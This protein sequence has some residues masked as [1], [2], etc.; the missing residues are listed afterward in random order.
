MRPPKD[1]K[2]AIVGGGVCGLTCAVALAREGVPVEVFEAAPQFGEVGAG[3]GLGP[4]AIRVLREIGVFDEVLSCSG[5]ACLDK[6]SFLFRYGAGEHEVIYDYPVQPDD[7]VMSIHR[8]AFLNGL[9][10]NVD[11]TCTKLNKRCIDLTTSSESP[12]RYILHFQDGTTSEADVVIGADGI[13]STIR[14]VV[15]GDAAPAHLSFSNVVAYRGL[16][17][18]EEIENAGIT[19]DITSRPLL[20]IGKDKVGITYGQTAWMILTKCQH[21][22]AYTVLGGR[23]LNLVACSRDRTIPIGTIKSSPDEPWATSVPEQQLLEEFSTFGE[24]AMRMLKCIRNPS[25][26]L[27]HVVYPPLESYVRGRVALLGDAAHAMLPHLSAGAGQGVEDAFV[28]ARLLGDP[29]TNTTNLEEVLCA[30]DLVRRPRVQKIWD[31]SLAAGNCYE[32]H[33]KHGFTTEGVRNDLTG[34]WDHVWHHDI[35]KDIQTA[36]EYLREIGTF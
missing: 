34:Q 2:V 24:D 27:I 6:K 13:K 35:V 25:K 18:M 28:L 15:A 20:F 33:G 1:F 19:T 7:F 11:P 32:G 36:V 22:V 31:G 30:Y 4:N 10:C 23:M 21:L 3:M 26:W 9:V 29:R 12:S 17:P 8:A 16:V 5:E 14:R